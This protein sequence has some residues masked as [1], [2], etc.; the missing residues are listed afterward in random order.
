MSFGEEKLEIKIQVDDKQPLK[1]P[2]GWG[3][4]LIG[5]RM[6]R[7]NWKKPYQYYR[8]A[9]IAE[10]KRMG[11]TAV[12]ITRNPQHQEKQDPGVAV[13]FGKAPTEDFSWQRGLGLDNPLPSLDEIDSAFRRIAQR[14]HPDAVANGSGGDVQVYIRANEWRKQARSY[15][16]GQNAPLLDNCIPVDKFTDARQNIAGIAAALRHFRGL[17]LVGIPA[18]LERVM[19]RAFKTA[20]PAKASEENHAQP[21]SA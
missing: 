2:D 14:H 13:W 15:V 10:L 7:S 3:R 21:V 11:V 16:L 1:W 6:N 12:T 18:I 9:V 19:D 4:T 17:E 5:E 8:D 20:L